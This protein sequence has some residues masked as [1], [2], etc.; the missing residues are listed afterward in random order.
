MRVATTSIVGAK[1]RWDESG[2]IFMII[3][4]LSPPSATTV[5]F[6]RMQF[7]DVDVRRNV[8]LVSQRS[9]STWPNAAD[10]P[11][12]TG[13]PYATLDSGAAPAHACHR[14]LE[15]PAFVATITLPC[16][17]FLVSRPYGSGREWYISVERRLNSEAVAFV[18][19]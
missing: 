2:R 14:A 17:L 8:F 10:G 16:G 11:G 7:E 12:I 13:F 15:T 4:D 3:Y 1:G 6:W 5:G 9:G 18:R 19:T